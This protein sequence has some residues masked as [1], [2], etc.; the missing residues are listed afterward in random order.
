MRCSWTCHISITTYST[1]KKLKTDAWQGLLTNE[2]VYVFMSFLL[3]PDLINIGSIYIY[4]PTFTI[5]INHSCRYIYHTWTVWLK[6][7]QLPTWPSVT[8]ALSWATVDPPRNGTE[9]FISRAT[10]RSKL[11]TSCLSKTAWSFETCSPG[12][13]LV[14]ILSKQTKTCWLGDCGCTFLENLKG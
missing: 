9:V 4:L 12:A 1:F 10:C 6:K 11:S 7:T 2:F 5:N 3:Q 14:E 8:W 13:L